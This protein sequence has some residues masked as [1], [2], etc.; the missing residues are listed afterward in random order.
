[1]KNVMYC[2]NRQGFFGNISGKRD[3]TVAYTYDE[4]TGV[5]Q[6]AFAY[7][8]HKDNY[9]RRVGRELALERL[10]TADVIDSTSNEFFIRIENTQRM[11]PDR[12]TAL[13]FAINWANQYA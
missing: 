2:H 8:S 11:F 4:D 6:A 13:K 7:C 5:F 12:N 1:M 9:N 10:K 3:F